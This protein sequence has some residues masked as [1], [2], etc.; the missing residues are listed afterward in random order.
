MKAA[1]P[2]IGILTNY[3]NYTDGVS[4][5]I[6]DLITGFKKFH[7]DFQ[8]IIIC[9]SGDA[10]EMF[11]DSHIEFIT[12]GNFAHQNRSPKNFF[13]AIKNVISISKKHNIS[14]LHAHDHYHANIAAAA[15]KFLG[16]PTIQTNHGII[17]EIGILPHFIADKHI[18]I[19]QHVIE[20]V[21]DI[22]HFKENKY[23]FI[24][25]GI[26]ARFSDVQK[27]RTSRRFIAAG[28][29]D[30]TK[31]FDL[32]IK[33]AAIMKKNGQND[34]EFLLAGDGPEKEAL[35]AL[36]RSSGNPVRFCGNVKDMPAL[37]SETH[38][39]INPSR[40][41]ME[42]FPRT[43][44]EAV[45]A[46]NFLIT[47]RFRGVNYDFDETT[48]GLAFPVDDLDALVAAIKYYLDNPVEVET[49]RLKFKN[50]AL[51]LFSQELMVEKTFALYGEFFHDV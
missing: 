49:R 15:G 8:F 18:I 3:L 48:D 7:D 28:R 35:I 23:S 39:L 29:F 45:F 37:F 13:S 16:L 22:K 5:H 10:V 11:S 31:G 38:V 21:R 6:Y 20:Y 32:Y 24:R 2:A 50:K 43:I 4:R 42:G 26:P 44:V 41:L 51:S 46:D 33:A 47:S 17:P 9:D 40:S 19:N 1:A 25:C 36:N 34:V 12:P 27:N 14:L 30:P